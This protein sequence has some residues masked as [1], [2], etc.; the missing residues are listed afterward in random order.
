MQVHVFDT[1]VNT[2]NGHYCHFDVLVDDNNVDSVKQYAQDY[3][4][5]IGIQAEEV[6]QN[7]C[8]FCHSEVASEPVLNHIKQHGYFIIPMQGCPN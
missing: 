6:N 7:R 5:S 1:H 4:S 8:V 2:S 3:L